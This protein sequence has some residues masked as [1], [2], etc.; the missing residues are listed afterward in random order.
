M[1]NCVVSYEN[2]EE[3]RD[4]QTASTSIQQH[5]NNMGKGAIIKEQQLKQQ[6]PKEQDL[7]NEQLN[8][9]CYSLKI[10]GLR[11]KGL[12]PPPLHRSG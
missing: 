6:Y 5:N 2:N 8:E 7:E 10:I 1:E 9:V 11:I 12:K 4:E 3:C